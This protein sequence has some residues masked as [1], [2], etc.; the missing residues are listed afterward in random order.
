MVQK[1]W[2]ENNLPELGVSPSV[3]PSWWQSALC[4]PQ[5]RLEMDLIIYFDLI[6]RNDA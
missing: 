3:H 1:V 6:T 2:T 5:A 4:E